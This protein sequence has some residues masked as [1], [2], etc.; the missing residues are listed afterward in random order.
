MDFSEILYV[1]PSGPDSC[2]EKFDIDWMI[3]DRL[4]AKTFHCSNLARQK[5]TKFWPHGLQNIS[6]CHFCHKSLSYKIGHQSDY[7]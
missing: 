5:W 2:S 3:Y 4:R 7:K 6:V 1:R